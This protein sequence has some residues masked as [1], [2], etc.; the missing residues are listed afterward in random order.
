MSGNGRETPTGRMRVLIAK[1]ARGKLLLA[2]CGALALATEWLMG[3]PQS[4]L[5]E[6]SAPCMYYFQ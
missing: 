5:D 2:F 6:R 1:G 3:D 4:A